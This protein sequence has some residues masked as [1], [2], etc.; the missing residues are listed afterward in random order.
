M[1]ILIHAV[2]ERMW[3]VEKFLLPSLT[4]QGADDVRI[5][6]DEKHSGN[7]T[8]CM[9]AFASMEGDGATWHIQDDVIVCRDFVERCRAF[10]EDVVYGFCCLN[11]EDRPEAAGRVYACDAWNSFQCLKIPNAYAREC[12][13][14]VRSESWREES[15]HPELP[16]L[17]KL[18]KGDDTFFHEFLACRH[19]REAIYN[20]KPNLV[21]HIDYLIGGSSLS[22]SWGCLALSH[23]WEDHELI[24]ELK[25]KIREFKANTNH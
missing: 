14:W 4:E 1:T 19:G 9:D 3:Y 22:H 8:A 11:F 21:N 15:P 16:V 25:A 10:D 12:A 17:W 6:N 23:Y 18:N 2:P 13:E 5:W 20:A 7:L 24:A